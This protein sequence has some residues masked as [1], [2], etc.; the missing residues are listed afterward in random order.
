MWGMVPVQLGVY[1]LARRNLSNL[2]VM[3]TWV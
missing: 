1:L 3:K 2:K